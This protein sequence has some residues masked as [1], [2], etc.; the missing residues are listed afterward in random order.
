MTIANAK[1]EAQKSEQI[2]ATGGTRQVQLCVLPHESGD[3]RQVQLYCPMNLSNVFHH[4]VSWWQGEQMCRRVTSQTDI[5]GA[6]T[7]WS[8]GNLSES[9]A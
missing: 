4:E 5:A 8:A 7:M 1:E 2:L 3:K 6:L 9:D